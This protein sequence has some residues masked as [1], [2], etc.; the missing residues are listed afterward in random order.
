MVERQNDDSKKDDLTPGAADGKGPVNGDDSGVGRR[1]YLKMAGIAAGS[2][3]ASSQ[4]SAANSSLPNAIVFDGT[5][6]S[7]PTEYSFTVSDSVE[8][9]SVADNTN[10]E[11]S[12]Q[13]VQGTVDGSANAYVYSGTIQ[14]L[15]NFGPGTVQFGNDPDNILPEPTHRIVVRSDSEISYEFTANGEVIKVEDGSETKAEDNDDV[16]QNGDG[17]WSVSG[18]TGNGYGDAFRYQGDVTD[19]SPL[20]GPYTLV[21]DG[22]ETTAYDLTGTERPSGDELVVTSSTEVSYQFKTD[23]KPKKIQDG[24]R[25]KAEGNDDVSQNDDGTWSV[26]G[27]TGN[28][29]GDSYEL[30]GEVLDFSPMT[31]SYSLLLNGEETTAYELTGTEPPEPGTGAVLGGGEGYADTVPVSDADYTVDSLSDLKTALSRAGSGD[32]V[33]LTSDVNLSERVTIPNGVTLASDRGINGSSGKRIHTDREFRMI[34]VKSNARITGIEFEGPNERLYNWESRNTEPSR[35]YPAGWAL[36]ITGSDVEI[37]NCE[38]AQFAYAGVETK[39]YSPHIHH[40]FMHHNQVDGLGYGVS[41]SGGHPTIEYCKFNYNRHSVAT[42]SGNGGFTIENCW[43][44]PDSLQHVIDHHGP[45]SSTE[46]VIRN[47]TVEATH[48][49]DNPNYWDPGTPS[50]ALRVRGDGTARRTLIENNWFYHSSKPSPTGDDGEAIYLYGGGDWSDKNATLRNNHFGSDEPDQS[51]G[52][53][54][55]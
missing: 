23:A 12:G 48:N 39:G 2:V 54:R 50:E 18:Y 16:T 44:G 26:S 40:C 6:T 35:G 36:N 13:T 30:A 46:M 38:L 1:S 17:T 43:F 55:N 22:E 3:L 5:N 53:P 51:I 4:A 19:F 41:I 37:D 24:S 32:V 10:D 8:A 28:G 11:I 25:N 7:E 49:V 45:G 29:Y 14:Q 9:A 47:S 20:E 27:Y 31:G 42:A 33:Y 15:S 21:V 52:H 34:D